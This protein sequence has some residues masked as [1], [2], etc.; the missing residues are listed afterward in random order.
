MET[1]TFVQYN[2][3]TKTGVQASPNEKYS[4]LINCLMISDDKE[5][6]FEVIKQILKDIPD[7]LIFE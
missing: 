5:Y 6:K 7:H 2:L 1:V 3:P 4:I